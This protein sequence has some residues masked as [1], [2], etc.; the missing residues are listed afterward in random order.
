MLN[1]PDLDRMIE[2]TRRKRVLIYTLP[3]YAAVERQRW[4]AMESELVKQHL[5]FYRKPATP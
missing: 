2:E 4:L 5:R 3:A 1:R